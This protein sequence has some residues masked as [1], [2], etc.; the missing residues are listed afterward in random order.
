MADSQPEQSRETRFSKA[1]VTRMA[2]VGLFVALGTTAVVFMMKRPPAETAQTEGEL[3]AS[4]ALGAS[5][6]PEA[7]PQIQTGFIET[8]NPSGS[9][10]VGSFNPASPNPSNPNSSSTLSPFDPPSK[11]ETKGDS[12]FPAFNPIGG[13]PK[14]ELD[15]AQKPTGPPERFASLDNGLGRPVVPDEEN[16]T[17]AAS[18]AFHPNSPTDDFTS[19]S[20]DFNPAARELKASAPELN[21]PARDFNAAGNELGPAS[22]PYRLGGNEDTKRQDSNDTDSNPR[23]GQ[24]FDKAGPNTAFPSDRKPN[25]GRDAFGPLGQ[26][27]LQGQTKPANERPDSE[28]LKPFNPPELINRMAPNSDANAPQLKAPMPNSDNGLNRSEEKPPAS[29]VDPAD[30]SRAASAT[31]SGITQTFEPRGTEEPK[32]FSPPRPDNFSPMNANPTTEM[33]QPDRLGNS[34]G[35][36]NPARMALS[37]PPQ[38]AAQALSRNPAPPDL[39]RPSG[40]PGT[41]PISA[42]SPINQP[43]NPPINLNGNQPLSTPTS[44][45]PQRGANNVGGAST[46]PEPRTANLPG[47]RRLEGVQA[48]SLTVEKLSP[49]EVSVNEVADFIIVI[50]NIGRVDADDVVVHDQVPANTEFQSSNPPPQQQTGDRRLH[51]DLGTLKAGQEKRI[52]YQLKPLTPGEIGSVAQ[53][54]FS[55]Q[56]SMRTVVTQPV[57]EIVH[58][59]KP[60]AMI[61]SEVVFDVLVTNK[62]NGPAKNVLIQEDVPPQLQFQEGFRELEYEVGNL[63]PG[64]SKRVQLGLKA[65]EV[66]KLKNVVIATATG[67]QRAQHELEMEV[68]APKLV[69][70][71]DGPTKRYLGRQMTHQFKIANPGT[72]S[73]TNVDLIAKLPAGLRFVKANNQGVYRQGNHTVYWSMAE[74]TANGEGTVEIITMPIDS[75]NQDI[76]FEVAADLNQKVSLVQPLQIEHLVDIFFD[77]DDL[78]DPIEV[79]AET[80]YMVKVGNQGTQLA[81]NVQLQVDFPN[82]MLPSNVESNLPSQIN[83]QRVQFSP[84]NNLKPGEQLTI[85]IRAKGQV[86]GD[87]RVV[88]TLQADGRQSAVAKEE[89]TRVY[90][91][92]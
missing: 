2:A 76:Q 54:S 29:S 69:V 67:G 75:G 68:V 81:S 86:A 26:S 27:N 83:G 11:K 78:V 8:P 25:E 55:T 84:I 35:G 48:P 60:I 30:A 6:L 36:E 80:A 87:H 72:A 57:L 77:V 13:P 22:T 33:R 39:N 43:S 10:T 1:L 42:G 20:K 23:I 88:V 90:S 9:T 44:S 7:N 63:M 12:P 85:T 66:G 91:D 14:N 58:R 19:A 56:A 4:S 73:A 41:T 82:G 51:W 74:L 38:D 50:R 34:F 45:L 59:T 31:N 52:Q 16:R 46:M 71:A 17:P 65:V 18:S 62:G 92:R 5:E 37:N 28:P 89:I 64:Q 47:E 32:P 70:N 21:A 40:Q 61:G 15:T 24:P 3:A 53:V 79:G 49:K